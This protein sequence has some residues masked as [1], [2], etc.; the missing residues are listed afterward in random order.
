MYCRKCNV[1]LTDK[2]KVS[3]FRCILCDKDIKCE[4]KRKHYIKNAKKIK[5][6]QLIYYK[7]HKSEN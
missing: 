6:K 4:I 2:N 3:K 7:I 5:E 1:I